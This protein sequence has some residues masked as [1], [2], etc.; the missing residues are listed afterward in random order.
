MKEKPL[1]SSSGRRKLSCRLLRRK[2]S[3]FIQSVMTSSNFCHQTSWILKVYLNS[4]I[5]TGDRANSCKKSP[6]KVIKYKALVSG[7]GSAVV[8]NWWE[9][10]PGHHCFP[11]TCIVPGFP[12]VAAGQDT[13]LDRLWS[14]LWGSYSCSSH[15]RRTVF[16]SG[17]HLSLQSHFIVYNIT[18]SGQHFSNIMCYPSSTSPPFYKYFTSK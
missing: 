5:K 9:R 3:F 14:H 18:N 10:I 4:K 15:V 6:L 17:A 16:H 12:V 8:A 13:E 1:S 2:R 7:S 11:S